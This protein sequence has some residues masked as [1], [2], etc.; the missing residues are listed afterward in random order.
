MKVIYLAHPL[1]I[2]SEHPH[3]TVGLNLAKAK[4]W[5]KWACE[6]FWPSHAF[7][8]NWILNCEVF[9]YADPEDYKR[10]MTRN[11]LIAA[12][13]DELWLVGGRITKG[14]H[15]EAS[16]SMQVYPRPVEVFDL[17]DLGSEPPEGD[18]L[19]HREYLQE[20]RRMR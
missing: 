12:R 16:I 15:I 20:L 17:T 19:V 11:F 2:S 13:C 3:E 6:S 10:G 9:N 4:R 5:Y 7:I 18:G 1:E 8:C 14:M